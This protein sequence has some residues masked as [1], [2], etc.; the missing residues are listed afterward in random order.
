M[1]LYI[2]A[3]LGIY[4]DY[5]VIALRSSDAVIYNASTNSTVMGRELVG[6]CNAMIMSKRHAPF[7]RTWMSA[8]VDFKD[9]DWMSLSVGKPWELAQQGI[10]DITVLDISTWFFPTYLDADN[11]WLGQSYVEIDNNYGVH[12]WGSFRVFYPLM[13]P[14]SVR[15]IDTP[16]FC[17][18]RHLFDDVRGPYIAADW[19]SNPN[20]SFTTMDKLQDQ[21]QKLMG[22]Y[23]FDTDSAIKIVDS[24]GN[25]LHGWAPFG[26]AQPLENGLPIRAFG[27]GE[28]AWIPVPV[29]YDGRV[30]TI[31]I[32]MLLQVDTHQ[33]SNVTIAM[34]RL[35]NREIHIYWRLL[36]DSATTKSSMEIE[37]CH[38]NVESSSFIQYIDIR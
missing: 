13:T 35:D 5:N 2:V 24:S 22:S 33:D 28:N 36:Y 15:E 11:V 6:L 20:C 31:A 25:N 4:M 18:V 17:R 10:H 12:M 9:E 19:H 1:S 14:E 16:L 38:Q 21:N 3:T 26:T 23:T 32:E 8:Y 29:D 30:G 34:L 27:K 37:W 7:M